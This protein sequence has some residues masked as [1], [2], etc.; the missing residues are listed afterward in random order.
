M[1]YSG[2]TDVHVRDRLRNLSILDAHEKEM[3]KAGEVCVYLLVWKYLFEREHNA[4]KSFRNSF[5]LGGWAGT[6]ED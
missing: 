2:N 1:Q 5:S 6:G 4:T 3:W